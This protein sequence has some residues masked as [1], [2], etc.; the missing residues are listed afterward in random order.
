MWWHFADNP[1]LRYLPWVLILQ[2]QWGRPRAATPVDNNMDSMDRVKALEE[3]DGHKIKKYNVW[4][5]HLSEE[6][7]DRGHMCIG[8]LIISRIHKRRQPNKALTSLRVKLSKKCL[9]YFIFK[10]SQ[11]KSTKQGP[12]VIKGK[13][14][15]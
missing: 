10:N 5:V 14:F 2:T 8:H 6:K 1:R 11:K 9:L 4:K 12:Y 15:K 7:E 13:I 3:L